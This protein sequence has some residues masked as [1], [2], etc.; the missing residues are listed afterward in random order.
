MIIMIV[1]TVVKLTNGVRGTP[2]DTYSSNKITTYQIVG[3][4]KMTSQHH[5]CVTSLYNV[6]ESLKTLE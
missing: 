2:L 1:L 3:E 6:F 5:D 4:I